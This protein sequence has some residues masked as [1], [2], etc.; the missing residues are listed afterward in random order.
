M[1]RKL[2][3]RFVAFN[4]AIVALL[5]TVMMFMGV[6][7]NK[8]A[9]REQSVDALER[10][11][12]VNLNPV[13]PGEALPEELPMAWFALTRTPEGE[14]LARG[15][16][17][18]DL[19]DRE[20]LRIL[21]EEALAGEKSIGVLPERNLRYLRSGP[22][23]A[24]SDMSGEALIMRNI[25]RSW[26]MVGAVSFVLFFLVSVFLSYVMTRPVE[27]AWNQQRQ[28]IADASH[29]LKTPLSVIMANAELAQSAEAEDIGR[30]SGNILT[31]SYQ[32][33]SLVERMLD[34][35][36]MDSMKPDHKPL[37]F[38]E[39]VEDAVLI[40]QLLFQEQGRPLRTE[41]QEDIWIRGSGNYLYQLMDVLLDNALKYSQ[42]EGEVEVTLKTQGAVCV[43][44]VS[45]PGPTLTHQQR[46]DVFKRFY[47][48][49]PARSRNGSYGL[50]LPIAQ[51]VAESHRGTI[52]ALS[53]DGGNTF[54]VLLPI[55][56]KQKFTEN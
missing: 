48:V 37:D 32:M 3:A 30:F 40:M 23:V 51:A 21:L 45:S 35:A 26:L 56:Q 8:L 16:D 12:S 39:L 27:R 13:D 46:R 53:R 36:R 52:R 43:L 31:M 47:R 44:T 22:T 9:L 25:R 19:S 7:F 14:L 42:G 20:D 1:I 17:H 55:C 11:A 15:S 33:R 34:M 54:Q 18:Y 38:S 41:I 4:M 28:F 50:G 6:R 5:L 2:R 10:V 49:D 29:E 24:F